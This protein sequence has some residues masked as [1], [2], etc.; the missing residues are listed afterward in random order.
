M[1]NKT[2][3]SIAAVVE[4]Q[5]GSQMCRIIQFTA[6]RRYVFIYSFFALYAMAG[7]L[8]DVGNFGVIALRLAPP[9]TIFFAARKALRNEWT[10]CLM[11]VILCAGANHL[12]YLA[13]IGQF[14]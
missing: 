3:N 2:N 5:Q 11:V 9:L 7:L 8:M 14:V 13:S 10:N 6:I 1:T 4:Y 12:R